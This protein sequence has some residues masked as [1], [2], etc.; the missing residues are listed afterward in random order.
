MAIF[1][2]E[3]PRANEPECLRINSYAQSKKN[4]FFKFH[5]PEA[6]RVPFK[7]GIKTLDE[8]SESENFFECRSRKPRIMPRRKE[9]DHRTLLE[10]TPHRT[11]LGRFLYNENLLSTFWSTFSGGGTAPPGGGHGPPGPPPR[12]GPGYG[13]LWTWKNSNHPYTTFL[14]RGQFSV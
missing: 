11:T 6:G 9:L 7:K 10:V 5:T 3:W 2:G 8:R 14:S 12:Y 1:L 4:V 13:A